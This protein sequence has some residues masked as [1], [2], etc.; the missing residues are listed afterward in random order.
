MPPLKVQTQKVKHWALIR[1]SSWSPSF[2]TVRPIQPQLSFQEPSSCSHWQLHYLFSK[3]DHQGL[4][5]PPQLPA[6][7]L[8][9]DVSVHRCASFKFTEKTVGYLTSDQLC[10]YC[11]GGLLLPGWLG[12]LHREHLFMILLDTGVSCRWELISFC[13][14]NVRL[15]GLKYM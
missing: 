15:L 1:N 10:C 4:R 8:V 12:S 14:L 13:F 5:C 3:T 9:L 6:R 7:S 2:L 11:S